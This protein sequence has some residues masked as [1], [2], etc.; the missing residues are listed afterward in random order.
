[1]R[2]L[3]YAL[4]AVLVLATTLYLIGQNIEGFINRVEPHELPPVSEHARSLH[5]AS[6][7]LDMH[8]D[9]ALMGR[10]LLERSRFGHVD[11][12]RLVQGGVGMQFFTIPTKVP[13]SRDIHTT[14]EGDPDVLRLLGTIRWSSLRR[15][16]L[17]RRAMVQVAEVR[18][19]VER[20][21][22]DFVAIR[23][24]KDLEALLDARANGESRVGS[25]LG[26]EGAHAIEGDFANLTRF[27]V[28]GVRMIGLTHFFDNAFAGSAHGVTKGGLTLVGRELVK[29]MVDLGIM[30]DL[31]HLSPAAIDDVLGLVDVPTVVS[32]TGVKGTCDNPRNLSDDHVRAIAAGGG[33]I[34]I[35]FFRMAVCG[36]GPDDIVAAM[37]HVIKLVGAD[38]VAL[39][40]D[41]DGGVTTAFDVSQLAS[42]TQAMVD[43]KLSDE[44]IVKILGGNTVRVMRQVL[45]A[46]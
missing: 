33:V 3:L 5:H 39:G 4:T 46:V 27:H 37:L 44:E 17:F 43:A 16:G 29:R 11:L 21:N 41:F 9:S 10:D 34:G 24:R 45:P 22:G 35:G 30:I 12:P 15:T 26:L 6:F 40:S 19:A 14:R 7:V 13:Y 25:L 23:T 28:A 8:A 20:S 1:M 31:A 42:V 32:H 2:A 36:T 18:H 38:H